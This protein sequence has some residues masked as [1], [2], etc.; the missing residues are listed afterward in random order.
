MVWD[1]TETPK[2]TNSLFYKIRGPGSQKSQPPINQLAEKNALEKKQLSLK[3]KV[4]PWKSGKAPQNKRSMSFS[5]HQFS[6]VTSLLV[7][8]RVCVFFKEFFWEG[9]YRPY[10]LPV[11][12][13]VRCQFEALFTLSEDLVFRAP[14]KPKV[15]LEDGL[16]ERSENF[17]S[18][19][20]Q[21][22]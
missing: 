8:G 9:I 2:N 15:W 20:C 11:M 19:H 14:P 4:Y 18:N 13:K 17:D 22:L 6:G 5:K 16:E 21:L 1:F 7:S 10:S 3:L 12:P